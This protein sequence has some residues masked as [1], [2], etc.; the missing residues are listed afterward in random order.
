M[1]QRIRS[2]AFDVTVGAAPS[3]Q[4]N[5]AHEINVL[6]PAL[7][8]GDSV[9]LLSLAIS[10]F[11]SLRESQSLSYRDAMEWTATFMADRD[12]TMAAEARAYIEERE[13]LA[14]LGWRTESERERWAFLMAW[15]D[16]Y[17]NDEEKRW[18]QLPKSVHDM[19]GIEELRI[20]VAPVP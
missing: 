8:Y 9:T 1:T 2:A 17:A 16:R 13:R 20:G 7:L 10:S 11:R 18:S 6:R 3:G 19:A 5:I 15:E 14:A 12:P 4:L